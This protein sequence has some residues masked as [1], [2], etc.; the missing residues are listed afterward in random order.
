MHT[1]FWSENLNGKNNLEDVVRRKQDNIKI[2]LKG[3]VF[4]G[5]DWINL[6][7]DRN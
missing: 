5:V 7:Q 3:A 4:G 2:Y 1:N 6:A